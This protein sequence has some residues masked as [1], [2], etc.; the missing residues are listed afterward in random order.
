MQQNVYK[1]GIFSTAVELNETMLQISL[2]SFFF[3]STVVAKIP[4]LYIFTWP[5]QPCSSH[6][7]I[8]HILFRYAV[9]RKLCSS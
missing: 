5:Y 9:A 2:R 7:F 3:S 1:T 8:F 4:A 6:V